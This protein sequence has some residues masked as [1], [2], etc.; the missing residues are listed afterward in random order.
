MEARSDLQIARVP[1]TAAAQPQAPL[2]DGGDR[3]PSRHTSLSPGIGFCCMFWCG[4]LP[5]VYKIIA[6]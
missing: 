1:A 6:S 3:L 2:A 4:A 5:G